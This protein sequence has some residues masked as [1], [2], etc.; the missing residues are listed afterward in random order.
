[1]AF[2]KKKRQKRDRKT[3]DKMLR[4]WVFQLP[5]AFNCGKM[6]GD[7]P[8]GPSPSQ[9]ER[10]LHWHVRPTPQDRGVDRSGCGWE[11]VESEQFRFEVNSI[12]EKMVSR[13]HRFEKANFNGWT[14]HW[15]RG[16][17]MADMKP[18]EMISCQLYS[19]CYGWKYDSTPT[20]QHW[21]HR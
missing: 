4:I 21:I 7:L 13:C 2:S 18:F 1:M 15:S 8:L 14:G 20:G 12:R 5:R 19:A 11:A 9:G 17:S 16:L 10:F 6:L 3:G